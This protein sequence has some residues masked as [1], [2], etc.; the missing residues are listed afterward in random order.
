MAKMC[1]WT[2][3]WSC[4]SDMHHETGRWVWEH[5]VFS[6]IRV[7]HGCR[8]RLQESK[9]IYTY[10]QIYHQTIYIYI[11]FDDRSVCQRRYVVPSCRHG[12]A[13]DGGSSLLWK[14]IWLGFTGFSCGRTSWNG[15]IWIRWS[16]SLRS[17]DIWTIEMFPPSLCR[18][19]IYIYIYR[20]IDI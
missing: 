4:V 2:E 14:W 1:D 13:D 5:N 18:R 19:Y 15:S 8:E 3:L 7:G 16:S 12:P 17:F 9:Y 6:S 10:I 20:N 11:S